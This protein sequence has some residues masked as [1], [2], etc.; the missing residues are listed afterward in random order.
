MPQQST[1]SEQTGFPGNNRKPNHSDPFSAQENHSLALPDY[2][3]TI[4]RLF[5]KHSY[6]ALQKVLSRIFPSDLARILDGYSEDEAA[7]IFFVIPSHRLA[8]STLKYMGQELR[9]HLMQEFSPEKLIP[10][11]EELP[12]DDRA[13]I[14]GHLDSSLASRFMGGLDEESMREVADLLQ[15]DSDTAG[16]LMTPDFFA[17]TQNATVGAAIETV[18]SLPYVEMVFYLYVLDDRERLVGVSSL[19]QLIVNDPN[20]KLA[21]IMTPRIISVTT[22]TPSSEVAEM[23]K[24]YRLL[25]VPVVDDMDVLVGVVTVDDVI[26]TM[27]QDLSDEALKMPFIPPHDPVVVPPEPQPLLSHLPWLL[28]AMV[29]GL[30]AGG[31]IASF[32]ILLNAKLALAVFIPLVMTL[33]GNV[34]Q[35]MEDRL[36]GFHDF[37]EARWRNTMHR[38]LKEL[39]IALGLGSGLGLLG[40]LL[41][42]L[43]FQ[44][45]L[46]A[47]VVGL[48]ILFN[49]VF[50]TTLSLV[51]F[52]SPA[53][54]RPFSKL[55][56]SRTRNTLR[57]VM[58][59]L[60]Y[61]LIATMLL[62]A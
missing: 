17:L 35:V 41:A 36:K 24:H 32:T 21:E 14:I 31:I 16:G 20:K 50:G 49:V 62:G 48:T 34:G 22:N 13:D 55:D 11:L 3:E 57:D 15:Y 52:L 7:K 33:V 43:F 53:R 4:I 6:T 30:I 59:I 23:V 54:L 18:R 44:E 38:L 58:G 42:W 1:H 51:S 39:G 26:S 29:G 10:I 8:A 40:G 47:T 56:A 12:P 37:Q 45:A 46:L 60:V 27:E 19:R 5:R 61:F 9:N 28:A 2:A 25:G